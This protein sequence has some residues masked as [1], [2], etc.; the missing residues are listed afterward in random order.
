MHDCQGGTPAGAGLEE[1]ALGVL[2]G[3]LLVRELV[4]QVL[5]GGLLLQR[6]VV[7]QPLLLLQRPRQRLLRVRLPARCLSLRSHPLDL[8]VGN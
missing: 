4:A 7:Q 2:Q 1:L 8:R 3:H 5:D 6:L